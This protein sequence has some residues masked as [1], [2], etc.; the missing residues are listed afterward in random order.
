M[1]KF[2]I[3]LADRDETYI[4]RIE[5]RF[6]ERFGNVANIELISDPIYFESYF[7]QRQ[8]IDWLLVNEE[9]YSEQLKRQ[10]I[11]N[12]MRLSETPPKPAG[13]GEVL[14]KEEL[15]L[16]KYISMKELFAA[17]G[18]G[19]SRKPQAQTRLICVYAPF[20]GAGTTTTALALA[21]ALAK[22]HRNVLYLSTESFQSAS[23]FLPESEALSAEFQEALLAGDP[24]MADLLPG[25]C[26]HVG[27]DYLRPCPQTIAISGLT[28]VHFQ[29]LA[30]ILRQAGNYDFVIL[31]C[32]AEFTQEKAMLMKECDRVVIVTGQ[33]RAAEWKTQALLRDI[34][35]PEGDK[36]LAVC[37]RYG[38]DRPDG[39][40]SVL[41]GK[42]RLLSCVPE[43]QEEFSFD[44]K[45]L[46]ED[47]EITKLALHLL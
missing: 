32:S 20:G 33:G 30:E 39:I 24:Q 27:F 9:F 26:G 11:G 13:R 16:Y 43:L 38:E 5:A 21:G 23:L 42:L 14:G 10:D 8:H 1:S 46:A 6:L 29:R 47:G 37:N 40:K 4:S 15:F 28:M 36:F 7:S 25:Q 34:I 22:R 31:D 45:R 12:I 19:L 2:Q 3:V 18:P 44:L 17:M 41:L 35:I